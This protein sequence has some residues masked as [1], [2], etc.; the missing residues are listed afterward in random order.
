MVDECVDKLYLKHKF[1]NLTLLVVMIWSFYKECKQS[2][3]LQSFKI[4]AF[5]NTANVLI[6]NKY[7]EIL[8]SPIKSLFGFFHQIVFSIV[9]PNLITTSLQNHKSINNPMYFLNS[10]TTPRYNQIYLLI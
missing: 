5:E 9:S 6:A 1:L 2:V 3:K 7:I 10:N 4:E 8:I